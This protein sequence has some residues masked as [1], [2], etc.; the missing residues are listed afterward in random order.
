MTRQRKTRAP[1]FFHAGRRW[2][3]RHGGHLPT[4][5]IVAH[6]GPGFKSALWIGNGIWAPA[7]YYLI[8]SIKGCR[9]GSWGIHQD[10]GEKERSASL[11]LRA[12]A[13]GLSCMMNSDVM[14]GVDGR[15]V[16]LD[17]MGWMDL[18]WSWGLRYRDGSVTTTNNITHSFFLP[19]SL[20]NYV[21]VFFRLVWFGLNGLGRRL[22]IWCDTAA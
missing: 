10:V 5:I 15:M 11:L 18:T 14:D 8:L 22:S 9:A 12:R 20:M 1:L 17:G 4:Y 2:G 7:F 6:R 21:L 16:W 3:R 19:R 13:S